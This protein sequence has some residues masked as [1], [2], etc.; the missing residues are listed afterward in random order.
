MCASSG[1]PTPITNWYK[2]G[3]P[4]LNT[5]ADQSEFVF[6]STDLDNRG[7]YYCEVN[8][9]YNGRLYSERSEPVIVNINS[10]H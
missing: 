8:S 4:I 2:D 6:L 3:E 9:T 5:N 1:V 7:I 10:K